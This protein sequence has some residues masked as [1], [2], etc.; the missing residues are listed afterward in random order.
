[1]ENYI[2]NKKSLGHDLETIISKMVELVE[3]GERYP[4]Y[5]LGNRTAMFQTALAH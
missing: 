1:M 3:Q 4:N 2:N 5:L